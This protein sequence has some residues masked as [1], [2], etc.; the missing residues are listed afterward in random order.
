MI[1]RAFPLSLIALAL[2]FS[3]ANASETAAS[4][5]PAASSRTALDWDG[6]YRGRLPCADCE[7]IETELTLAADGRYLLKS[8][9]LGRS[10]DWQHE[11]GRF[12]WDERGQVVRL[13]QGAPETKAFFVGENVLWQLDQSGQRI[14]GEMAQLYQLHK[15]PEPW[16]QAA[17]DRES[18][19]Q[20]IG[21]GVDASAAKLSLDD[22]P[23]RLTALNGQPVPGRERPIYIEFAE[24]EPRVHGFSGCNRFFAQVSLEED[25]SDAADALP[26][27][28]S[29][30]GMT[31]M[32]CVGES[33][34]TPFI[35]ALQETRSMRIQANELL[36][37]DASGETRALFE[38]DEHLI[39]SA[40]DA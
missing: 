1:F 7:A 4:K 17:W 31:R 39:R 29:N 11:T 10:D 23:W 26:L 19:D 9:Y 18:G 25:K 13:N 14:Q 2:G 32:A 34:E 6:R 24:S 3:L 37:L 5:A 36:L 30:I 8:R 12:E 38:A 35:Q 20:K 40:P 22:Q 33:Q 27:T 28:F 21:D 16:D 15:V